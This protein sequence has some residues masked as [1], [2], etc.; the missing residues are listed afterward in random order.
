M[1]QF[2]P[3]QAVSSCS[4]FTQVP[5]AGEALDWAERLRFIKPQVSSEHWLRRL[6]EWLS[7]IGSEVLDGRGSIAMMAA[8]AD[9]RNA[10]TDANEAGSRGTRF[11]A[12]RI[13]QRA[14]G[15]A[16]A[17][18]QGR[19]PR[20]LGGEEGPATRSSRPAGRFVMG[21]WD[22]RRKQADSAL[23]AHVGATLADL[24]ESGIVI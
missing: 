22:R 21:A 15:R 7:G 20:E 12:K 23:V 8:D 5:V 1:R 19:V 18:G 11:V 14:S 16:E 17:A 24:P 10:W 13:A 2:V 9:F 6:S 4:L 3:E